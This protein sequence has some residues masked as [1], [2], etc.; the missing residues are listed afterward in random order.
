MQLTRTWRETVTL[1]SSQ[2]VSLRFVRPGDKPV[3][4]RAF[5]R[6]S[7]ESRYSRFFSH[8]N[9]LS[10][11]ELQYLT[12]VD[13]YDHVAIVAA[14]EPDNGAQEDIVGFG[15]ARYV[16]IE[17]DLAEVAIT[18]TDDMQAQGLG[19]ILI[20]RLAKAAYER[21]VR[22]F[23]WEVLA[24]NVAALK[25]L[26]S[27]S[28]H[29]TDSTTIKLDDEGRVTVVEVRL[30]GKKLSEANL[31]RLLAAIKDGMWPSSLVLKR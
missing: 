21:G 29:A 12:E 11:Q 17:G 10:Q 5:T 7:A 31:S 4:L 2:Q 16:R 8:K 15:V 28:E 19:N 14:H 22:R 13:D 6:L 30:D 3:F 24:E 23:R 20:N 18:I 1:P 26:S 25:L 9:T 27:F